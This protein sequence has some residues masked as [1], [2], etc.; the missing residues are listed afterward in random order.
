MPNIGFN[1][2]KKICKN[3][4]YMRFPNHFLPQEEAESESKKKKK[5]PRKGSGWVSMCV[6][7][8]H[9]ITIYGIDI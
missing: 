8:A 5:W 7:P 3:N 4:G 2:K 1:W 9:N 6:R